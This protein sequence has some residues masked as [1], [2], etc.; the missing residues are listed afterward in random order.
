MLANTLP[1]DLQNVADELRSFSRNC[2]S[3]PN[4]ILNANVRPSAKD[5]GEIDNAF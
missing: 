4:R 1:R 2:N 3:S 5:L